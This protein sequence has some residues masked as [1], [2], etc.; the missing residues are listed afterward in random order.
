MK[1]IKRIFNQEMLDYL[2]QHGKEH[3]VKDWLNIV[4]LK[5]NENFTLKELQ[6]YFVRHNIPVKY[7]MENKR[8]NAV[9]LPIGSERIKSD[10]MHQ[11]KIGEHKWVNKQR[12]LYEQYH[13]V[14]LKD[15]EYVIFLDQDKT[16]FDINNLKVVSRK[17]SAYMINQ[18]LF[19]KDK[20]VTNLGILVAKHHYKIKEIQDGINK[21]GIERLSKEDI[22]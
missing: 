5:F 22:K 6:H 7:E 14:K 8:N 1:K 2:M 4:N 13:N 3:I 16:N 12:Y 15:N 21:R 18:G 17:E 9:A 19:S 11:V 20:S 10:G